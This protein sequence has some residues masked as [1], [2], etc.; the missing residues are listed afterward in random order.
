MNTKTDMSVGIIPISKQGRFLLV[1]HAGG[2]W[3]FPKGHIEEG[4]DDITAARRE[5]LE[6]A[7]LADITIPDFTTLAEEYAF[8]RDGGMISKTVR[9][10][11]GVVENEE[12]GTTTAPKSE[13]ETVAWFTKDDA[14]DKITY[15][16][17]KKLLMDALAIPWVSELVN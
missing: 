14:L 16:E 2:H 12:L 10:Y 13:I 15:D 1:H 8:V 4:E 3:G 17:S 11:V 6:E 7:G 9:Y 5:L